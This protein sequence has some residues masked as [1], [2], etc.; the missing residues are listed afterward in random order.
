MCFHVNEL[1]N[2]KTVV[3]VLAVTRL[4]CLISFLCQVTIFKIMKMGLAL[5]LQ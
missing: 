2:I 3:P 4:W 5:I 1:K